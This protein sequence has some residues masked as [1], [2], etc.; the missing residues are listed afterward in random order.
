MTLLPVEA[1]LERIL[2]L[3]G[4]LESEPVP[5]GQALGRA[6]SRD[7]K[8]SR[9]LPPWDN[10][11]MDGYA[12]RTQDTAQAGATLK[13][14][15]TI[16]AGERPA[17]PVEPGCCA[18]IMTGAQVPPGADAVVMQ[19]K[20]RPGP[21]G[22]VIVDEVTK[23]G[24]NIRRRGEDI[25]A[26]A[27]M[28][29]VGRALG[30]AEQAAL[31][32]QGIVEVPVGRKPRVAIAS[33][34]DELCDVSEEPNGRIVDTNAP[35]L[36]QLVSLNGGVPT[37]LGRAA[38]RLDAMRELF[39]QGLS[40][41]VLVTVAGAS[42][43][44]KDFT[45][46][47][48]ESLGVAVDFWKVAM[49]PGKPLAVGRKDSTLVFGLPGNPVSAMVTFELFVRPA[50]RLLQGLPLGVPALPARVAEPIKKAAGLRHFV[51]A[52]LERR[53]HELWALPLAS[54][55][56]GALASAVGAT[57]LISI[58]PDETQVPSGAV[59]DVLPLS[60]GA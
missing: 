39:R 54:Q 3:C 14:T 58:P 6:L 46:E 40:H 31:W 28:L 26:G 50:L 37:V 55:S 17:T 48:L 11:A 23:A 59:V 22:A 49:K 20:T 33:S 35:V 34:G 44:E 29:P 16:H 12:V 56:S 13:V 53:G 52:R 8:A 51:R 1:A 38:D 43:G 36:A 25:E 2:R 9:T 30:V 41:D 18:R 19:E 45:R 24:Q 21:D 60:W 7:V 15:S 10:S 32:A 27:L 47:A 5:V 4:R 42:V 57:H